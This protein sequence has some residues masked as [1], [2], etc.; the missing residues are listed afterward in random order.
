MIKKG[1]TT[2]GG[3]RYNPSLFLKEHKQVRHV[4]NNQVQLPHSSLLAFPTINVI[5]AEY[6]TIIYNLMPN[7]TLQLW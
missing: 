6:K 4:Q 2:E 5:V 3:F 7:L 1:Q